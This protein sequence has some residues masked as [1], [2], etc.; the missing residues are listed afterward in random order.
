MTLAL[1]NLSVRFGNVTALATVSLTAASGAVTAI[2]GEN[3]SGKS[4]LVRAIAGLVPSTG[5]IERSGGAAARIGYMPQDTSARSTLTVFETVLLGRLDALGLRVGEQELAAAS[6]ILC[7]LGLADLASR[8]I[9]TLSG[10]QRQ[11][12][13]LAQALVCEPGILL[14]DEPV[15]ALDIRHQL[16]VLTLV[17]ELTRKRHLTTLCVLHDLQA[18]SRF[19]DRI[20]V[21]RRGRLIADGLPVAVLRPETLARAY[22]VEAHI[23]SD[24]HGGVTVVPLS[25]IMPNQHGDGIAPEEGAS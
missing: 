11:L 10:G 12:V 24:G 19:A 6:K 18:A 3:G 4:T 20:V 16:D 15:S 14:L 1:A 23:A 17:R 5:H 7:D 9:G 25:G 21:L 13:F 2:I 22:D 8:Q